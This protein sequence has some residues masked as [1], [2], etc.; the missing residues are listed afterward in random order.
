M[1]YVE[2]LWDREGHKKLLKGS[3]LA[4]YAQILTADR[5]GLDSQQDEAI[6]VFYKIHGRRTGDEVA[7]LCLKIQAMPATPQAENA[8]AR[9]DFRMDICRLQVA[10]EV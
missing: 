4:T 5:Q 3:R 8:Q 10:L 9:P 1:S 2:G 7:K 6:K